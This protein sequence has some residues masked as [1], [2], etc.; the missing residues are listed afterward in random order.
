MT[1]SSWLLLLLSQLCLVAGQVV[2]KRGL[3]K[4]PRLPL[5]AAGIALLAGW[6]FLWVALLGR[7]DLSLIYPFQGLSPVLMLLA[8]TL[9]LRERPTWRGGLGVLLIAAGTALVGLTRPT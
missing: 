3:T 2:L 9:F 6:F 1:P 4:G 7:H 5:L 8:S